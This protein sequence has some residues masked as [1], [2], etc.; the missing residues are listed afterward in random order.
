[1]TSRILLAP[2]GTVVRDRMFQQPAS[3]DDQAYDT[4]IATACAY[5]FSKRG[6]TPLP[7][8]L[9][10]PTLAEE[11]VWDGGYNVSAPFRDFIRRQTPEIFLDK[12]ILLRER[13][14]VAA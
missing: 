8:M 13:D 5:S 9:S 6:W 4:L 2:A 10:A 7:W 12:N 3:T 1:M 14:L 11:W